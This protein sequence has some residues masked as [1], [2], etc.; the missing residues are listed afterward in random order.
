MCAIV[1]CINCGLEILERRERRIAETPPLE[2]E[3]VE[4]VPM[5]PRSANEVQV[6][7]KLN[8][9]DRID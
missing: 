5:T 8:I 9:S 2:I 4:A 1:C 7:I 3:I 6:K